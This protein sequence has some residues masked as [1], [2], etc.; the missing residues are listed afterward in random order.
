MRQLS[1]TALRRA[2]V[3]ALA[4]PLI[5][6]HVARAE[7][8]VD[9]A[10]GVL[11]DS[12]TGRAQ[13]RDDIRADTA[14]DARAGMAWRQPAGDVDATVELGVAVRGARYHRHPRLSFAALDLQGGWWRKLGLGRDAPWVRVSLRASREDHREDTRDATLADLRVEIGRRLSGQLDASAGYLRDRRF[15]RH[16]ES[17]VPGISG[18]VWDVSGHT[19]FARASYATSERLQLDGGYAW[20]RGDVVSTSHRNL[21]IFRASD[22]IGPTAAF[23]PDFFDYRLRGTTQI[24][25]AGASY[26]LDDRSSLNLGYVMAY[27]RAAQGLDYRNH[28]VSASWIREW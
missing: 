12:N 11:H 3:L 26:A 14:V 28:V 6:V 25:T 13:L 22:A 4:M 20:R 19:A 16:D 2:A 17:L 23:G 8:V 21:A 5:G 18:A 24:G 7:V 15:A 9:A 10:A 1:G 27:T